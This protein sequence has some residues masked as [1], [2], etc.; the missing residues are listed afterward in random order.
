MAQHREKLKSPDQHELS[1]PS[2]EQ[3]RAAVYKPLQHA[4]LPLAV[5]QITPMKPSAQSWPLRLEVQVPPFWHGWLAHSSSVGAGS[6]AGGFG[7][8]GGAGG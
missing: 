7:S 3:H 5:S 1:P 6:G 2:P 8:S 4:G